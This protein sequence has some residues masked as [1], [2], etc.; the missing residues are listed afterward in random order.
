MVALRKQGMKER[1]WTELKNRINF[2]KPQPES[3]FTFTKVLEMGLMTHVDICV[4][5]G[6]KAQKEFMI[7]TMLD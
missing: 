5:V 1:H 7:E 4:E 2:V 3:E 6:E